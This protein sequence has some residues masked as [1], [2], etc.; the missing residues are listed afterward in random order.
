MSFLSM[1]AVCFGAVLFVALTA[2]F[3]VIIYNVLDYL[4]TKLLGV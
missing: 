2:V 1:V 3:V 4:I